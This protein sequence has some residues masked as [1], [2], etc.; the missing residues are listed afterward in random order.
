MDH[1]E[2]G[3]VVPNNDLQDLALVFARDNIDK[4]DVNYASGNVDLE[5]TNIN[6]NLKEGEEYLKVNW[7][8]GEELSLSNENL[9]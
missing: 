6:I 2:N 9:I 5:T 3:F 7:N 4:P 8:D 1:Y